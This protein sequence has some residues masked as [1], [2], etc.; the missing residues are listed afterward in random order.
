MLIIWAGSISEVTTPDI[1]NAIMLTA[2]VLLDRIVF[3]ND[4]DPVNITM[5]INK[6]IKAQK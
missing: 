4:F 1:F 6:H 2:G 3:Y 5:L